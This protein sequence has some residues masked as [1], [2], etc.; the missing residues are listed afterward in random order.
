MRA[1]GRVVLALILGVVTTVGVAWALAFTDIRG[2][3]QSGRQYIEPDREHERVDEWDYTNVASV[4]AVR[5]A[6]SLAV[7]ADVI[8]RGV[9]LNFDGPPNRVKLPSASE[10]VPR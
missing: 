5:T 3:A 1:C 4:A 7:R 2:A 10:V 6:G 8:G 9:T